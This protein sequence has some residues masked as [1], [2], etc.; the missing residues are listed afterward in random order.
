MFAN[1]HNKLINSWHVPGESLW[2]GRNEFGWSVQGELHGSSG[3][4]IIPGICNMTSK[5]YPSKELYIV[6]LSSMWIIPVVVM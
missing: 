5:Y 2:A 6:T 3:T 1:K 4:G